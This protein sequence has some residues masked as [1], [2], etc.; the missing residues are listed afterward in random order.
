MLQ[1]SS[2]AWRALGLA[3]L[4]SMLACATVGEKQINREEGRRGENETSL[5]PFLPVNSAIDAADSAALRDRWGLEVVKIQTS[6]AGNIVDFRYRVTDAGKA[7]PVFGRSKPVLIDET[8]RSVLTVAE[9][10][11]LGKLRPRGTPAA[12][13]TYAILFSNS[14]KTVV[15]GS[16]VAVVI[17]D[18]KVRN[19]VVE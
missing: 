7:A 18:F 3:A 13:K 9:S 1:A 11:K 16:H 15:R 5:P 6:A 14:G 8:V 4:A 17:G 12:G 10:D 2:S 19:L